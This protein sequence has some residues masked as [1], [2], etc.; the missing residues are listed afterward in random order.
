MLA[1]GRGH[2]ARIRRSRS[3]IGNLALQLPG[4]ALLTGSTQLELTV[5]AYEVPGVHDAFSLD[6]DITAF[7]QHE[8]VAESLVNRLRHMNTSDSRSRL[9]P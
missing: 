4:G 1:F 3:S 6:V 8:A 2:G 9:H 5:P 7:L